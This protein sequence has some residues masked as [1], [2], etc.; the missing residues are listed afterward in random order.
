MRT[1][2]APA[3][4][5]EPFSIGWKGGMIIFSGFFLFKVAVNVDSQALLTAV[6]DSAVA[7]EADDV[8]SS[9]LPCPGVF[10]DWL[11]V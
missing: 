8:S 7:E 2:L 6:A 3:E 10:N 9:L 5:L 4:A 11:L 1:A